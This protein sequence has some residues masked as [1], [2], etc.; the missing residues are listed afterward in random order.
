MK[1]I[2]RYYVEISL[3]ILLILIWICGI[4]LWEHGKRIKHLENK[5]YE[6]NLNVEIPNEENIEL[7][8]M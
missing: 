5:Q 8:G 3:I 6:I 4:V 1:T 7:E 2:K